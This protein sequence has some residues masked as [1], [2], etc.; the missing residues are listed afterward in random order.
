ME[1][2]RI[3]EDAIPT[4][5]VRP[6]ALLARKYGV[7]DWVRAQKET[8]MNHG[9]WDKRAIIWSASIL[10]TDERRRWLDLVQETGDMLERVV[11][12]FTAIE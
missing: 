6:F 12:Q 11:A 10:P 9:G 3:A 2:L 5:G 7:T 1:A 4:L 8:W